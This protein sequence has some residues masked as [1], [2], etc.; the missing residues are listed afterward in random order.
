MKRTIM[1]SDIHGC[2]DQLDQILQLT[3]YNSTKDKLILLGDYVDRGPNSKEVVDKVIQLVMNHNA[4]A[5]RGNHDQRLV[6]LINS[7]SVTVRSKFLEHG[8]KQTLQSYCD[9]NN[10]EIS[11]EILNQAIEF[12]KTHYYHHIDYISKL[13]FYHEDK[14]HIYVHAGLNPNFIDWK[15]Q[16][17]HDFMYIKDEF[18]RASFDLNKKIIFGH[19]KTIDIHGTSD[20]WFSDD[21]IG[22]DGGCAYGMQL[23]CLIFQEGSYITEQIKVL[24]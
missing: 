18:I 13:P 24:K 2:I 1:I 4:I 23:N 12:I 19:T 8:G 22:I 20:I 3:E 7:D 10:E 21:K 11:D 5:L 16:P 14:D 9:I 17:E 6:D 15:N